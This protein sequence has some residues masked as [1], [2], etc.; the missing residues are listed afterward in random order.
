MLRQRRRA[1]FKTAVAQFGGPVCLLLLL[2]NAQSYS[3]PPS[4]SPCLSP[5]SLAGVLGTDTHPHPGQAGGCQAPHLSPL[6]SGQS[7]HNPLRACVT[8]GA[9]VSPL[10]RKLRHDKRDHRHHCAP[11]PDSSLQVPAR[12]V[13]PV[14]D[15]ATSPPTQPRAPRRPGAVSTRTQPAAASSQRLWVAPLATWSQE[16]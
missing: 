1:G 3:N 6:Q 15:Q 8:P 7:G 10:L 16:I 5:A 13:R 2:L 9:S 12:P 4:P 14:P 11:L